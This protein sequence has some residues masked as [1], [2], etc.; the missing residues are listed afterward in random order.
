MREMTMRER[1]LAVVQGR[2]LDRVPFVIYDGM[3]PMDEVD[4]QV[5]ADRI[6]LM[7]WSEVHKV[8]TPH[9]RFITEEYRVGKDKWQRITL[10]TPVGSIFEERQFEPVFDSS[11]IK[12]HYVQERRDYEVLWYYLQDSTIVEDYERYYRDQAELGERGVPLV[13]VE[14]TPYQNLWIIWVGLDNL[15]YHLADFPECVEKT[16]SMLEGRERKIFD[17][18]RWSPVQFIDFPDNITAQAIGPAR[19]RRHCTALYDELAGMLGEKVPVFV[20]MDGNLKPLWKAI[21]ES[22]VRGLDSFTPTPDNDTRVAEAV[23]LWPE[24]RLFVNF[25]SSV[26]LLSYEQVYSEAEEIL[27]VAGHTG[28]LQIQVSENVPLDKWQTSFPAIADAIDAFG[29]P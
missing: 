12:K 27:A 17:I 26:H 16:F 5:G 29:K 10:H 9:C 6:G 7:R 25:P 19:F 13:A 21:S 24:M 3:L 2:E 15:S 4:R 28:H 8:I 22:R 18:V 23:A 11:S 14:R 1:I 20:H